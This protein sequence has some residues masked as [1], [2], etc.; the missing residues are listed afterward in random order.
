MVVLGKM[1][2]DGKKIFHQFRERGIYKVVVKRV[3]KFKYE[4]Q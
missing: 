3:R 2:H 1:Q 4:M